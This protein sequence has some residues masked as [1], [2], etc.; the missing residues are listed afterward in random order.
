MQPAAQGKQ[1]IV[2]SL[3]RFEGPA[4]IRDVPLRSSSAGAH[5]VL[6][7]FDVSV[8]PLFRYPHAVFAQP[9]LPVERFDADLA[10]LAADLLDTLRAAPGVGITGPHIGVLQRIVVLDLPDAHGP[11]VYVN[12]E[13]VAV[14]ADT[15]Q[16]EEGSIAMPGVAERVTRAAAVTVRYQDLDARSHVEQAVGFHA[17]CHQHEIDQLDGRFWLYRLSA[18]KRDRALARYARLQRS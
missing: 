1:R 4:I 10:N 2:S 12:P 18:L 17:A 11:V 15:R 8:R 16:H 9:A 14:S 6:L 7:E 3:C 13:I 5:P